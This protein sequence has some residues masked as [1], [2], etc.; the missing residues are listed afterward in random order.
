MCFIR[1]S[2]L[3]ENEDKS[4]F[5]WWNTDE[6]W[7]RRCSV[8]SFVQNKGMCVKLRPVPNIVLLPCR[9]Q[10]KVSFW[11]KQGS[12]MPL[13]LAQLNKVRHDYLTL[14]ALPYRVAVARFGFKWW[15]LSCQTKFIN[16]MFECILSNLAGVFLLDG[17]FVVNLAQLY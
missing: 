13:G 4:G 8:N 1:C 5:I 11:L 6:K 16:L 2:H 3:I 14:Q 7:N 12:S 10:M 9:T 17:W 15:P